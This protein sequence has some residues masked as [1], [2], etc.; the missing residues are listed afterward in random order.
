MTTHIK[1]ADWFYQ[2]SFLGRAVMERE[3]KGKRLRKWLIIPAIILVGIA[4]LVILLPHLIPESWLKSKAEEMV[5]TATSAN[6]EM[7]RVRWGWFS[8]VVLKEVSL[9]LPQAEEPPLL[10]LSQANRKVKYL[11]LL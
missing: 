9:N 3:K 11:S 2:I 5:Q 4:L 6:I 7:G 10:T 1:S 8:G